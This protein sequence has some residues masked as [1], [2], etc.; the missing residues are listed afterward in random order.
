MSGKK[1][2]RKLLYTTAFVMAITVLLALII[3]GNRHF[4]ITKNLNIFANLFKEVNAYYVDEVNPAQLMNKGAG[5]MLKELDPYTVYISEDKIE[6]FRTA[7]T[8]QYAG[9]GASTVTLNGHVYVSMVYKGFS[10]FKGGLKIGDEVIKVDGIPIE[11]LNQERLNQ[12]VKGEAKSK[13]KLTVKRP[14]SESLIDIQFEREKISIPNVPYSGML[15]DKVGYIKFTEFTNNGYRN[16]KKALQE[17]MKDDA[18]GIILDLRNNLGGLLQESVDISNLFIPAELEVVQT[19]GKLEA[20]SQTFKTR[21]NPVADDIPLVVLVNNMSASASEIVAGTM[22]DYDRAVLV[23]QK[24]YGKGLVQN[25]RKLPYNSIV[26]ITIAKYY[27]PSGRCIQAVDYSNRN[28]D[29]S[30]GSIPDSLKIAFKTKNGRTVYDGGGLDPEILIKKERAGSLVNKLDYEGHIFKYATEYYLEHKTIAP[31]R[32]FDLTD[33]DYQHFID[34]VSG[35]GFTFTNPLLKELDKLEVSAKE[36]KQDDKTQAYFN[37]MRNS[38]EVPLSTLLLNS[39]EE[40]TR[41]LE[42]EIASRYY[43]QPGAVEASLGDDPCVKRAIQILSAP[44]EYKKLLS[45]NNE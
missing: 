36:S 19:K 30:V 34:W 25:N 3:P 27:I 26:K 15:N 11:G 14:E 35:H 7:N 33:A 32:D 28:P 12:L 41:L 22:Q 23:G 38:L 16:V 20:N 40:V 9:I 45:P 39:Q 5:E 31:A 17:L 29:G 4:E 18:T 44:D 24:T 2:G 37:E 10:A 21:Y 8:G 6:D 42:E 43:L 13:V 1:P